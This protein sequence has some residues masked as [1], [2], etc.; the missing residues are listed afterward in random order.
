MKCQRIATN[1]DEKCQNQRNQITACMVQQFLKAMKLS[2]SHLQSKSF[3]HV[4]CKPE[5]QLILQPFKLL[6]NWFLNSFKNTN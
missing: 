3:F 4:V 5:G 6:S 2:C 1:V